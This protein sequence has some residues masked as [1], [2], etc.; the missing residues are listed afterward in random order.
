MRRKGNIKIDLRKVGVCL[1][2]GRVVSISTLSSQLCVLVKKERCMNN[3]T[4][5]YNSLKSKEEI[6]PRR[7]FY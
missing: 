1:E 4:V 5:L 6:V 7:W 2:G 3:N